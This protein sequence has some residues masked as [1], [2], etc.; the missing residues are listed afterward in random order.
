M[1]NFIFIYFIIGNACTWKIFKKHEGDTLK[2]K[3]F[4]AATQSLLL[5]GVLNLGEELI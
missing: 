3:P 2:S 4:S 5:W 1:M